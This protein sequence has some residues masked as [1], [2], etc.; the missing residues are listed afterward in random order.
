MR[1]QRM[2]SI[3]PLSVRF[4]AAAA[5]LAFTSCA[6]VSVR[7]VSRHSDPKSQKPAEIVVVPFQV[8]PSGVTERPV[9]R[10]PGRLWQEG[11]DLLANSLARELNR[12]GVRSSIERGGAVSTPDRWVV[13]GRITQL[14][15]GSR[16][17]RVSVGLGAGRTRMETEV[18]VLTGA[19]K[20]LLR[21]ST[22]GGSNSMPGAL[23]T[24]PV[25]SAPTW[26]LRAREGVT[27]DA[28]RTARMIAGIIGD[29]MVSRGWIA[30]ANVRRVK[31]ARQ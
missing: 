1:F 18:A 11:R 31:M 20:P 26:A 14:N 15:E 13:R 10:A 25:S 16:A 9:R 5:A 23:A 24:A 4:A 19:E 28:A 30:A 8:N 21:F 27:D 7:D 2:R 17:L 6:S 29:Y 12:M 22:A 3:L